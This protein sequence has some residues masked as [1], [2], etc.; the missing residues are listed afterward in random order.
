MSLEEIDRRLENGQIGM[1][2][3]IK[4]GEDWVSLRGFFQ[5]LGETKA[6]TQTPLI[7]SR[8]SQSGLPPSP[9]SDDSLLTDRSVRSPRRQSVF[10]VRGIALAC[11]VMVV[12]GLFAA[13]HFSKKSDETITPV[14]HAPTASTSPPAS[15]TNAAAS[16]SNQVTQS[17]TGTNARNADATATNT[18]VNSGRPALPPLPAN[19]SRAFR[20]KDL[21]EQ[22]GT[23]LNVDDKGIIIRSDTGKLSARIPWISFDMETLARE[24]KVIEYHQAR[25]AAAEAAARAKAVAEEQA[26]RRAEFIARQD[27]LID[28]A[29]QSMGWKEVRNGY[30]KGW[31]TEVNIGRGFL[32]SCT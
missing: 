17:S 7:L 26:R 12:G 5:G 31:G 6:V 15:I 22:V 16:G 19:E 3:Q 20:L 11:I 29:I 28:Q 18:E 9:P 10:T 30:L 24:P 23:I 25:V 13:I 2:S 8:P 4:I 14:S 21:T 32:L 27:E 1:L